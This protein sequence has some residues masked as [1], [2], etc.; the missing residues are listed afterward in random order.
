MRTNERQKK[1]LRHVGI[2]IGG[3]ALLVFCLFCFQ[4]GSTFSCQ[5]LPYGAGT[6]AFSHFADSLGTLGETVH[7]TLRDGFPHDMRGLVISPLTIIPLAL[8]LAFP[9][10]LSWLYAFLGLEFLMLPLLAA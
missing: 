5:A 1:I 8:F 9:H 3:L 4:P 10:I 6:S 7:A 2:R